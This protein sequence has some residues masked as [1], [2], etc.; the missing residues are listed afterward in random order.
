M[1]DYILEVCVDSVESA[2]A[3]V[4]G[5]AGRLELCAN[6]VIGGTTPGVSQFKQIRKACDVP[7]NVLIRPR[8]GDFL[9]T[10]HEFQMI[11]EDAQMFR[12]LGADGVV[13]GFLKP[14]GDLD[15]ER[16]NVLREKAGT[17]N[18]TLHR[19]F[20]VCRDPYRSLKEA[21]EAGIDTILTSGQQNTCMEGKKLLGELIGQAAGRID[22]LVG[23]G[24]NVDAIASLMDEIDA[25][26]FHMSGKTIVDSGM[27]YRKENVNM[28]I[29]GIG[30]YDIFRTEEEQIRQAKRLMEEKACLR[31][32]V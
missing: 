7:I 25:R 6:L 31:K 24:V 12:D 23:S 13:V 17:G 28:G 5:G 20:D 14:D 27:I 2:K 8:Y 26:C 29:P 21:M 11:S 9:Y 1:K 30:E 15:M 18:M 22:I 16:L 4:Q 3:A 19:A 32:S 10:E